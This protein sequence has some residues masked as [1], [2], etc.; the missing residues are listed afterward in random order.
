M[1]NYFQDVEPQLASLP[2]AFAAASRAHQMRRNQFAGE[3]R[4][5]PAYNALAA[6]GGPTR[7]AAAAYSDEIDLLARAI[8][9]EAGAEP[10]AG[11]LAVGAVIANRARTGRWGD[12]LKDVILAPGQFSAFN[13]WTGYAGG[14]GANHI[15]DRAPSEDALR[16]ARMVVAGQYEDPTGGAL[17][18]YNPAAASPAWGGGDSWQRIGNHVFGTAR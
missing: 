7:E 3:P 15:V 1:R 2:N 9:A 5:A 14:K 10:E 4:R 11:K 18:Y 17:N 8:D 13:G 12:G 6:Y 16:I